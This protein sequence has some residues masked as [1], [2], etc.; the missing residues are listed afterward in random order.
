MTGPCQSSIIACWAAFRDLEALE[1]KK[2]LAMCEL[3]TLQDPFYNDRHLGRTV[4]AQLHRQSGQ[5]LGCR[6]EIMRQAFD[7]FRI[8]PAWRTFGLVPE[9][10]LLVGLPVCIRSIVSSCAALRDH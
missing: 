6:A 8:D 3:D 4:V 5:R 1:D 9:R 7:A 10:H 2:E